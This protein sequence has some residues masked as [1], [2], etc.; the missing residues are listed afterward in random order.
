M[1]QDALASRTPPQP[2]PE[3]EEK[4]EE[5]EVKVDALIQQSAQVKDRIVQSH[6]HTEKSQLQ[7]PALPKPDHVSQ[8]NDGTWFDMV[9]FQ[10]TLTCF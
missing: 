8:D 7:V 9:L 10:W 2:V 6:T 1:F 5:D 3:G 4:E